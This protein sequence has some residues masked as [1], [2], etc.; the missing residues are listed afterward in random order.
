MNTCI[1][2]NGTEPNSQGLLVCSKCVA[3]FVSMDREKIEEFAASRELTDE[4]RKF[5][6]IRRG[7]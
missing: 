3:R 4:Q 7:K 1:F 6:G 5:L 2:C